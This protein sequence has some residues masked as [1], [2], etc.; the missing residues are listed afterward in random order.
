MV[1][2]E[3]FQLV[4]KTADDGIDLGD[5]VAVGARGFGGSFE[6]GVGV[7]GKVG[8]AESEFDEEGTVAVLLDELFCVGV[9]LLLEV[10]VVGWGGFDFAGLGIGLV[11]GE[12]KHVVAVGET[13]VGVEAVMSGQP[14]G[15]GVAEMPFAEE[16]GD[17]G[18][19][20]RF[21]DGLLGEWEGRARRRVG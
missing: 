2:R 4:E 9:E 8:R 7:F 15:T 19:L 6:V 16:A 18:W 21:G 1:E 5:D 10:G 12:R 3:G 11:D 17:V 13:V 20:E 14:V